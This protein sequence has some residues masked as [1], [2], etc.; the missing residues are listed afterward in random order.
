MLNPKVLTMYLQCSPLLLYTYLYFNAHSRFLHFSSLHLHV[1][2]HITSIALQLHFL[3]AHFPLQAHGLLT[4]LC[5]VLV[6]RAGV[7]KR[8]FLLATTCSFKGRSF[9]V[10]YCSTRVCGSAGS[11]SF[12]WS[13]AFLKVG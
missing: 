3:V 7:L 9:P 13:L 4:D 6:G 5:S 8:D 12:A 10:K 2:S 11:T 1:L